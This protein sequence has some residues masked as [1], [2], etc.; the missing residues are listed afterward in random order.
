MNETIQSILNAEAEAEKTRQAAAEEIR[1][2]VRDGEER[3]EKETRRI[4][5]QG[6]RERRNIL[7]EGEAEGARRYEEI[8]SR[9]RE[10]SAALETACREQEGALAEEIARRIL[11]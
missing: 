5:E 2:L 3:A 6:E 4:L 11:G 9:E 7:A 1:R 8:L 10:K